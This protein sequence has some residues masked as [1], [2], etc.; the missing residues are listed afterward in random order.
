MPKNP[1]V[2]LQKLGQSPWHDNIRR[3]LLTSG[4]LAKMVKAGDITGL[5]SNPTIFEQAISGSRAY[6][7]AIIELALEGQSAAEIFDTLAIED[8]QAAA[9]VFAPVYKKTKG[10]DGYVSIEVAPNYARD[11][12]A[13]I[14][15]AKRLWKTVDRPNLMVKIPATREGLPA[16]EQAIA[17]GINVN[18]TLI[19]SIQR[20]R[21]VMAAFLGGLMKRARKGLP[22]KRVASVASFFVSRVDTLVD[23][24]LEEKIQILEPRKASFLVTL[25]GKAA[26]ANAQLA[27]AEFCKFFGSDDF[28][29]LAKRGARVQ[30]PLWAS[31]STKNP[32]YPDVYYVEAL[33]GSDTVDT[34]PPATIVAYKDHGKP[35]ARLNGDTKDAERVVEQLEEFGV[36]MD[37]VT[38]QLEDEGVA[39]FNKSFD[40]LLAVVEARRQA[41][42]ANARQHLRLGKAQKSVQ[43]VL[44]RM[45]S[46]RFG[47]RLWKKDSKLWKPDDA[48]HQAEISIRLGWLDVADEMLERLS[49]MTTFAGEVKRAGFTHA[50]LCGMGG[51]SLAP[52][53]LR[54]TFG[55]AK[56]YLNL[57]VLDSTDPAA[58]SSAAERSDPARTLYIVSSKSGGTAEINAMFKFFWDRVSRVKGNRAGE[59]FIAIT[60]P[61]TSLEALARERGFRRTFINPPEIGGR[62]SALSFFGLVPAA[63][64]GMDVAKLLARAK[65]MMHAASGN[66]PATRNGALRLG[67]ALGVL[68]EQGRDKVTFITAESIRTFGY[69][70]E[71]LIAESTGKENKGILPVEGEAVAAPKMY[72]NDRVFV[73][74]KLGAKDKYD[75]AVKA[76]EQAGHP[77]IEIVLDDE[78]DLGGEFLRWEIATAVASWVLGIN[79]FDQPNVQEAKEIAK[80]YLNEIAQSGRLA[81][82]SPI[83]QLSAPDFAARF[84][85]Y[86]SLARPGDYVSLQAYIARTAKREAL[87]REL[88]SA[89]RDA[90]KAATTLGYGPRFLHSTGQLHKGGANNG[91][92]IQFVCDDAEDTPVPGEPYTFNQLKGAQALGDY[93]ALLARKRRVIRITLG[94]AL[95]RGLQKVRDVLKTRAK[96]RK[97]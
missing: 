37:A 58:V 41:V 56:G 25:K 84:R 9:D 4:A 65:E 6:D 30:R 51:S 57:A 76:L 17:E 75:K 86:L 94:N 50:L 91:L 47:E 43:G 14:A 31:T 38:Q 52:E 95:E 22:L 48:A 80:R 24:K 63:L 11:T 36:L 45:D 97:K 13:T 21:E 23:K 46:V 7:D 10:G 33:I 34:M 72:G 66:I 54:E 85:K 92:F 60:D 15:E 2:Q 73:H 87:L 90:T 32:A 81:D 89:I 88:Q 12:K 62:Y 93:G 83:L 74:L 61:G 82:T 1:L 29:V 42:L 39:S 59:N 49:D 35:Q 3:D 71:Q 40:T 5:T 18:V 55:V 79:P 77:V 16:I 20:Y 67:A 78:Y 44:T 26:I 64:L 27:Y 19:F 70:V 28:K 68:A 96:S 8:I 53:V 69:W